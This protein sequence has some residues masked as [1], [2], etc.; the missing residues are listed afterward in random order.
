V[1]AA[2]KRCSKCGEE[3]PLSEFRRDRSKGD[4]R[5]SSC[6][7][8]ARIAGRQS[9]RKRKRSATATSDEPEPR[10]PATCVFDPEQTYRGSVF[11]RMDFAL[12]LMAG[13]WPTGSEW[14]WAPKP[15]AKPARWRIV[16]AGAVEVDGTREVRVER[17]NSRDKLVVVSAE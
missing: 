13:Y 3:L 10:D 17:R 14:L 9:D 6:A 4:G 11:P 5:R 1:T 2:T 16:G 12:T 7:E 8:C 15:G